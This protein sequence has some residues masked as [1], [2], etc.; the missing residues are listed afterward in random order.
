MKDL[1]TREKGVDICMLMDGTGSMVSDH[2]PLLTKSLRLSCAISAT[3]EIPSV[4]IFISLN[5]MQGWC[6]NACKTKANEIM[7]AAGKVHPEAVTRVV[8]SVC[9]ISEGSACHGR[10]QQKQLL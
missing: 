8:S 6:L 10:Q 5:G 9:L 3:M 4:T 1:E 2:L 7:A